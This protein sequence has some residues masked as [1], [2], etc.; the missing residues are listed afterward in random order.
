M[1]QPTVSEIRHLN[2]KLYTKMSPDL[3]FLWVFFTKW[4]LLMSRSSGKEV[5]SP[6][7]NSALVTSPHRDPSVLYL[8]CR[9]GG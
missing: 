2:R 4:F 3:K 1:N 7:Q 8:F 6:E 5:V 9:E